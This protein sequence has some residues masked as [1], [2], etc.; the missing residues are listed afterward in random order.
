MC[1][2]SNRNTMSLPCEAEPREY[3]GKTGNAGSAVEFLLFSREEHVLGC[4]GCSAEE[5]V[6]GKASLAMGPLSRELPVH[7]AQ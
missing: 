1:G 5:G 2:T 4:P 7:S 3:L 6:P